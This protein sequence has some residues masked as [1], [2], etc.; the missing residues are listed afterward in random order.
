MVR[1]QSRSRRSYH[2]PVFLLR[3]TDVTLDKIT[4]VSAS[5]TN[6][7]SLQ[8][9][10]Q[11]IGNMDPGSNRTKNLRPLVAIN[12]PIEFITISLVINDIEHPVADFIS[13]LPMDKFICFTDFNHLIV[14]LVAGGVFVWLAIFICYRRNF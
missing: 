2:Y 14:I 5:I 1:R 9:V 7:F 13:L 8:S 4:T 12:V 11:A 3:T 10:F 6:L